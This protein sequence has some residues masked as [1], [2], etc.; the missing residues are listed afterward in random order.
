MSKFSG[1]AGELRKGYQV[2]ARL[3]HWTLENERIDAKG[4]DVNTFWLEQPGPL[5]VRLEIGQVTWV[6]PDVQM[7]EVGAH[8][9]VR[10]SGSPET[11][12]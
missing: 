2:V 8:C 9:A 3:R 12:R 6:W 10:V 11:R 7:L 4:S 5:S 1:E